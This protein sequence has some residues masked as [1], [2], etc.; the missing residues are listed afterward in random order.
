MFLCGAYDPN[1]IEKAKTGDSEAQHLLAYKYAVGQASENDDSKA[2]YWCKLSAENGFTYSYHFLGILY[3]NGRGVE[4]DTQKA[5]EWFKKS[6]Y[7][8]KGGMSAKQLA[9]L[10]SNNRFISIDY[11]KAYKWS[12]VYSPKE[13]TEKIL[14]LRKKMNRKEIKEAEKQA[15]DFFKSV[16]NNPDILPPG[17]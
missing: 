1:L 14:G 4:Q 13:N 6:A 2:F 10:Y 15:D 9:E 17:P 11:I 5:I 3:L 8:Y 12:M 7:I 16:K